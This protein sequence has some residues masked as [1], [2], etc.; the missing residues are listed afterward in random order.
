[1]CC[2]KALQVSPFLLN[3]I[4]PGAWLFIGT[5]VLDVKKMKSGTKIL[6]NENIRKHFCHFSLFHFSLTFQVERLSFQ[7]LIISECTGHQEVWAFPSMD[8]G[9]QTEGGGAGSQAP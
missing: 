3:T 2:L 4:I 1:M 5:L 6:I 9:Q 8:Q 7:A